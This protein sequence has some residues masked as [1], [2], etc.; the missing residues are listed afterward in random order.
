VEN[1]HLVDERI[2][3]GRLEAK[4]GGELLNRTKIAPLILV[5]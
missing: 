1:I 4:V 2:I 3:V 5:V